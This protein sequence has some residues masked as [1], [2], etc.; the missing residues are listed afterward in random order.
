MPV[1]HSGLAGAGDRLAVRRSPGSTTCCLSCV[2]LGAS[3]CMSSAAL[4]ARPCFAAACQ[5]RR[6]LRGDAGLPVPATSGVD[7]P[8]LV[9]LLRE[10]Q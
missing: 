4:D 5:E 2:L 10:E 3:V 8:L 7:R 6:T 1:L 9:E